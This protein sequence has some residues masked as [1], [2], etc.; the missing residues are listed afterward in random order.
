MCIADVWNLSN[1]LAKI[2]SI[3]QI[4]EITFLSN[5]MGLSNKFSFSY[6]KFKALG[7]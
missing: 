7:L 5:C 4:T 1:N 6:V 3:C 2:Q